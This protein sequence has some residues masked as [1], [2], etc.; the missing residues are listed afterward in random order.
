MA[1]N[2]ASAAAKRNA[3][4]DLLDYAKTLPGIEKECFAAFETRTVNLAVFHSHEL[5]AKGHK[6]SNAKINVWQA[7]RYILQRDAFNQL[8]GFKA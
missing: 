5:I 8:H 3:V 7:T 4:A 1:M 2:K 6:I